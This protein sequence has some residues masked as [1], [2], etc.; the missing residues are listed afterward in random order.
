MATP[1][2]IDAFKAKLATGGARSNLFRVILP[3]PGSTQGNTE[4][5]SF[6]IKS[7]L[8]PASTIAEI[9]IPFRGRQIKVAGDR[10]FA[11]WSV[12]VINDNDF[13]IRD[14]FERW[15]NVVNGHISNVG[16]LSMAD[17]QVDA[18]IEQLDRTGAVVKTYKMIGVFPTEMGDIQV[19][20]DSNDQIEE[21][22]VNFAVNNWTSNTTS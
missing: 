21:F 3:F 7:S 6:M 12:T 2:D 11:D 9:T 18:T 13:G 1:L 22:T 19:S 16:T 17:Y 14:S 8:L 4:L 10:T 5:A 20:Y 15:M